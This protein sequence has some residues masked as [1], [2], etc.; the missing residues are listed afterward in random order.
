MEEVAK[1]PKVV[2]TQSEKNEKGRVIGRFICKASTVDYEIRNYVP[3]GV[4]NFQ[5]RLPSA[6]D[7]SKGVDSYRSIA[8]ELQQTGY[9]ASGYCSL[10]LDPAEFDLWHSPY[11]IDQVDMAIGELQM[12]L[13][14]IDEVKADVKWATQ[15]VIRHSEGHGWK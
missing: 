7:C 2:L 14:M 8:W 12:R 3:G 11:L 6:T 5:Q 1:P 4:N 13:P 9:I 15:W 10:G